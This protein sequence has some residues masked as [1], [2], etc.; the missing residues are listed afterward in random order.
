APQVGTAA[1]GEDDVAFRGVQPDRVHIIVIDALAPGVRKDGAAVSGEA[2]RGHGD[3]AG[4]AGA[5][6]EWPQA[7]AVDADLVE[8]EMSVVVAAPAG[9][10][11]L[12]AVGGDAGTHHVD[13]RAAV[14]ERLAPGQFMDGPPW[15]QQSESAFARLPQRLPWKGED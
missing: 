2:H 8:A 15:R 10:D 5:A 12:L 9:E 6:G 3:A 11:D 4:V 14:G 13:E 1:G 7:A